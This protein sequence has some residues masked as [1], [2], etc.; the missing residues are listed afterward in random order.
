MVFCRDFLEW[1]FH[2]NIGGDGVKMNRNVYLLIYLLIYIL[3][4]T[5]RKSVCDLYMRFTDFIHWII[6][7]NPITEL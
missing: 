2:T 5:E 7:S 4:N 6:I 1:T 3:F